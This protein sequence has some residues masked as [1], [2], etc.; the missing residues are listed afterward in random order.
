MKW[1]LVTASGIVRSCEAGSLAEARVRLRPIPEGHSVISAAS[2]A[3]PTPVPYGT[4]RE[5]LAK[6]K[7]HKQRLRA[8]RNERYQRRKRGENVPRLPKGVPNE[9]LRRLV[10]AENV[11][12]TTDSAIARVVG[13]SAEAVRHTRLLL[14]LPNANERLAHR[15]HTY[16]SLGWGSTKIARRIGV[17]QTSVSRILN[18]ASHG[19]S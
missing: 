15:I 10:L 4:V 8:E 16:R 17:P 6:P 5:R 1:H 13:M 14:K 3:H 18:R 12:G 11:R 19:V 9:K 7:T 2:Y